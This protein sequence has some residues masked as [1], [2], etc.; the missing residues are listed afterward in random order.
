M[1]KNTFTLLFLLAFSMI[2]L[3]NAQVIPNPNFE[4]WTDII[5]AE[6]NSWASSNRESIPKYQ[7]ATT[8]TVTGNTGLGLRLETYI[9]GNDSAFGYI[10]YGSGNGDPT[11]G[12]GGLP[13][14]E[15]PSGITGYYR[16]NL[17]GND[18]AIMLVILKNAGN[19]LST[20]VIKVRG[21][22]TLSAFTQF[23]YS[24]AAAAT[25]TT[26]PDSVIIAFA[27]SNAIDEVGMENGSYIEL[28]E[29]A[30]TGTNITQP[31]MNGGFESWMQ[32]TLNIAAGWKQGGAPVKKVPGYGSNYAARLK[33]VLY[34]GN[35]VGASGLTNGFFPPQGGPPQAGLPYTLMSDTLYGYYKFSGSNDSGVVHYVTKIT[36]SVVGQGIKYFKTANNWTY[37]KMPI[38]S[39][40]TPDTMQLNFYSHQPPGNMNSVGSTLEIDNLY[41]FSSPNTKLIGNALND[42]IFIYPNPSSDIIY[43]NSKAL[44]P[45]NIV[46]TDIQ[47]KTMDVDIMQTSSD[48]AKIDVSK[49]NKGLY[50][51]KIYYNDYHLVRKI[52]KE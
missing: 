44:A 35:N 5:Y 27:S 11:Q 17:P 51:V 16:Y 19:V 45:K 47:G 13:Y 20:D 9:N 12:E 36:G 21:T 33:T 28:D 42:L 46:I 8:K 6:P 48:N 29:I 38:L 50:F 24:L 15:L 22:G 7:V 14:N 25:V 31:L 10:I 1:K 39:A 43:I 23:N 4:N 40:S 26:N 32:D 49:L 3:L 41:L 30:F 18:T 37:F 52:I 2:S 34:D